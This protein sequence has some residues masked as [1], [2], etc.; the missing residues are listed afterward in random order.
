MYG[1]ASELC[2]FRLM[3]MEPALQPKLAAQW[4]WKVVDMERRLVAF[5]DESIGEVTTW[6]WTF[7]D[8]ETSTEQNPLHTFAIPGSYTTILDVTGPEGTARRSKVWAVQL[9]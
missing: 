2:A 6:N 4:S 1:H 9:E 5:K 7:G 8:G 3:P